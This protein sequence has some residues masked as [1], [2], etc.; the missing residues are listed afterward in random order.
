M[1]TPARRDTTPLTAAGSH[2][3][4]AALRADDLPVSVTVNVTTS[5]LIF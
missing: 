1:M 4:P 3:D 2:A 5:A